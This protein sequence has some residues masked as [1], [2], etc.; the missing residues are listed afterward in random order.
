[1]IDSNQTCIEEINN[2]LSSSYLNDVIAKFS[3]SALEA[4][5]QQLLD[6]IKEVYE[7]IKDNNLGLYQQLVDRTNILETLNQIK[8]NIEA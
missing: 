3:K 5:E 1:M 8:L 7:F 6:Q 2:I 4:N